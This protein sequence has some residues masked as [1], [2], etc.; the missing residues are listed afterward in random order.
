MLNPNFLE[1]RIPT[2][3]DCPELENILIKDEPVNE[4][5]FAFGAL[6]MGEPA[7][8]AVVPAICNAVHHAAGIFFTTLPLTPDRII[9]ALKNTKGLES[10]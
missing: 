2:I 3:F 10:C 8:N 5:F 4:S 9:E 6:G 1:Y 7:I